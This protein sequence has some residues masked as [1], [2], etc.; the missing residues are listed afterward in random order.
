MNFNAQMPLA[1]L[2]GPSASRSSSYSAQ[3]DYGGLEDH[4][5]R[6]EEVA[7][8]RG[9][10]RS[11]LRRGDI[12]AAMDSGERIR[13]LLGALRVYTPDATERRPIQIVAPLARMSSE[14]SSSSVNTDPMQVEWAKPAKFDAPPVQNVQGGN[15]FPKKEPTDPLI[16]VNGPTR[17]AGGATERLADEG[18][19]GVLPSSPRKKKPNA[20]SLPDQGEMLA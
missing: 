6:Q 5:K 14:N 1:G 13:E 17:K 20:M 12:D 18:T 16:D 11:A 15:P 7:G 4:L 9:S 10:K 2:K 8:L 3:Y 19:Q